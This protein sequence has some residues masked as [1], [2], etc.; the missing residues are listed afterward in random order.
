MPDAFP[1]LDLEA[2]RAAKRAATQAQF[3]ALRKARDPREK[4]RLMQEQQA[5]DRELLTASPEE[6]DRLMTDLAL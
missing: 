1:S 3:E 5:R 2:E 6:R 4:T